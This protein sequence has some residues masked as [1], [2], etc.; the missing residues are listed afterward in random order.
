MSWIRPLLMLTGLLL[1]AC[2]DQPPAPTA[3]G[4]PAAAMPAPLVVAPLSEAALSYLGGT[5]PAEWLCR[6]Q[7]QLIDDEAAAATLAIGT[8]LLSKLDPQSPD[9]PY[10]RWRLQADRAGQPFRYQQPL[11]PPLL[12]ALQQEASRNQT[13][14]DQLAR[15]ASLIQAQRQVGAGPGEVVWRQLQSIDTRL[16]AVLERPSVWREL[17]ARSDGWETQPATVREQGNA[18]WRYRL[19]RFGGSPDRP[20][21]TAETALTAISD[22]LQ[23]Q[24]LASGDSRS[25]REFLAAAATPTL[26][27]PAALQPTANLALIQ[28]CN[29]PPLAGASR[30]NWQLLLAAVQQQRQ[31]LSR[32]ELWLDSADREAWWQALALALGEHQLNQPQ[33]PITA[34]APVLVVF[35]AAAVADISYH[36]GQL[37]GDQLEGFLASYTGLAES[38]INE[39]A[40]NIRRH[41]GWFAAINGRAA[42]LAASWGDDPAIALQQ[43]L[44]PRW[45][46]GNSASL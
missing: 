38:A 36:A 42:E 18:F 45:V 16:P 28:G 27:L 13:S 24:L 43:A 29:E 40:L 46:D 26:V 6:G 37:P 12:T 8:T 25:W 4:E 31:H 22:R 9:T 11:A 1:T 21:A 32:A 5:L 35:R 15:L 23:A 7:P 41:P 34:V 17:V 30:S 14:A 10:A 2:G 39:L 44:V 33:P 19:T 3:A 20:L